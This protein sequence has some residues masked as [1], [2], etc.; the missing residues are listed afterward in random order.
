M[1]VTVVPIVRLRRATRGWSYLVPGGATCQPGSLVTIPFH[2]R[3]TLG[4][5][6]EDDQPHPT[7]KL[8]TLTRVLTPQPLLLRPHRALI[9]YLAESG[10]ISLS[11]ALYIW[12]PAALRNRP[13]APV[14][15]MLTEATSQPLTASFIATHKQQLALRP[16]AQLDASETMRTK[17]GDAFYNS[18]EP[19]TPKQE[20]AHWLA[21]RRGDMQVV[22]GRER[23]LFAPFLNLQHVVVGEVDDPGYFHDQ[24][25]Y[26]SLQAVAKKLA[27]ISNAQLVLRSFLPPESAKLLWGDRTLSQSASHP[28]QLTDLGVET[29]L[30]HRL[31]TT[32]KATLAEGKRVIV[33]YNAHDRNVA[34]PTGD[35]KLLPGIESMRKQFEQALGPDIN[36]LILGTRSIFQRSYRNVGLCV[37]LNLDSQLNPQ[38]F[39]DEISLWSDLGHLFAYNCPIL[40]QA[41]DLSRPILHALRNQQLD[42]HITTILEDRKLAGLPP[43]GASII[44]STTTG[45]ADALHTAL[46]ALLSDLP[47]WQLS[48]PF[49]SHYRKATT[50]NIMLHSE[51][52]FVP[53]KLAIFLTKLARPWKV[54]VNPWHIL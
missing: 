6:W 41:H 13:T 37:A 43:F 47:E 21:V 2:G 49:S 54:Q 8:E 46:A 50:Q 22:L 9:E 27:E 10:L 11:T 17:L 20:F 24:L 30:N 16:S 48:Q 45:D 3:Q 18:F 35:A 51:T 53:S 26:I 40:A 36:K 7:T 38:H 28:V 15:A 12:L 44:C 4:V 42:V 33:L 1:I 25:P 32:I 23:A 29:V 34:D 31:L 14:L 5:V 52:S 19:E 39:A